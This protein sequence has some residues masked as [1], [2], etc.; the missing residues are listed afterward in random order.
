MYKGVIVENSLADKSILDKLQIVR[1]WQDGSWTLYEVR[2]G[3]DQIAEIGK[4]L[5]NGPWYVHFWKPGEDDVKVVYKDKIFNIKYSDRSTW[6]DAV[7]YGKSVGIPDEQLD[8]L[9][10]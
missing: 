9:I 2:V 6:Q 3:E 8:F 1:T 5:A 7:A 10:D 4:Y